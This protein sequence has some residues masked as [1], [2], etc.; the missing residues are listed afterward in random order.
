[1]HGIG[2]CTFVIAFCIAI[3]RPLH[4]YTSLISTRST[5]EPST[6]LNMSSISDTGIIVASVASIFG[7]ILIAG[8]VYGIIHRVQV[9]R[10]LHG[11]ERYTTDVESGILRTRAAV[12]DTAMDNAEPLNRPEQSALQQRDRVESEGASMTGPAMPRLSA[13]SVSKKTLAEEVEEAYSS[14]VID[15]EEE[16]LADQPV[17][18][19]VL[20]SSIFPPDPECVQKRVRILDVPEVLEAPAMIP[21]EV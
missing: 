11:G 21:E 7:F 2:G 12:V 19:G 13:I 4:L 17:K 8:T 14:F 9:R 1:M 15:D 18:R 20:K 3:I 5:Q 6:S 16:A 10:N